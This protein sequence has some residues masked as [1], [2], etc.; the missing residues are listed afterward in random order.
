MDRRIITLDSGDTRMAILFLLDTS[1]SMV[2]KAIDSIN[3]VLY[4][5]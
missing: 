5:F 4:G 3:T 2:G 1:A